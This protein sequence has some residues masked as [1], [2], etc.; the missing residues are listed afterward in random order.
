MPA[1]FNNCR[2]RRHAALYPI[3]FYD[4]A[5]T[6]P[7][8]EQA[9]N[10]AKGTECVVATEQPDGR[11]RVDRFVFSHEGD[12]PDDT[13]EVCRVFYGMLAST[14]TMTKAEAAADAESGILFNIKG[15]FK[16]LSVIDQRA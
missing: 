7:Q 11:V 2:D 5:T 10:L 14:R 13:G 9:R 12:H 6:G 1:Y 15:H 8:S 16:Q 3:P 4:L